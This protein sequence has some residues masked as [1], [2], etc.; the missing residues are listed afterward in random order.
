MANAYIYQAVRYL[1]VVLITT[2]ALFRIETSQALDKDF[3]FLQSHFKTPERVGSGVFKAMLWKIY[4]AELIAENGI[5][6]ANGNFAL[7][8]TYARDIKA[9]RIVDTS[10][11]LIADQGIGDQNKLETWRGLLSDIIPDI[12]KGDQLTGLRNSQGATFYFNAEPIGLLKDKELSEY[13]FN[14]WLA[15]TT[16]APKLRSQLL[17]LA[18]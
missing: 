13:F 10:I 3:E 1:V 5:Y 15:E 6:Q 9:Q 16:T 4:E 11:D 18:R 7:Q 14:I 12:N 17:G 2:S 8:L